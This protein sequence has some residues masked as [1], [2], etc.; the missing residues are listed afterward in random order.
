MSGR[1]VTIGHSNHS[2]DVFVDLLKSH[3]IDSVADVRSHPYSRFSPHFSRDQLQPALRSQEIQ[4][5][6][7][8]R[9]LGARREERDCYVDG[10]ARYDLII[11]LPSFREGIARVIRGCAKFNVALMC[12]EKDPIDCHRLV[13]ICRELRNMDVSISHVR[14]DGSLETQEDCESRLL[15]L[16]ELPPGDLF[17]SR[18]Q[19][20]NLAYDHQARKIAWSEQRT[21]S[22]AAEVDLSSGEEES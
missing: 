16:A 21:P 22:G 7:L 20:V 13:L 15:C 9:E 5:V 2:L 19:M 6:F 4:Y 17:S 12:S 3:A 8:G 10:Q 18:E 1:I 11:R 14:E